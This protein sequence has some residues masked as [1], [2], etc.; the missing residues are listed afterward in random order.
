MQATFFLNSN[1]LLNG[2][3]PLAELR[4]GRFQQVLEA[5]QSYGEHGAL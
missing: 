1:T 5:A 3:S 4:R 2:R